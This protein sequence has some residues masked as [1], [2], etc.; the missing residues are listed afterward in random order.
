LAA[1]VLAENVHLTIK[2]LTQYLYDYLDALIT[3]QTSP[4]EAYNKFDALANDQLNQLRK[5]HAKLQEGVQDDD[6]KLIEKATEDFQTCLER[7]A[8]V[9]IIFSII[10]L[11]YHNLKFLDISLC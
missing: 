7:L 1:D 11:I 8:F 2:Y 10:E 5:A 6:K 4:I 3:F 9:A